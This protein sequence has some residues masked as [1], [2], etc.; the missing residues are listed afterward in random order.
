MPYGKQTCCVIRRPVMPPLARRNF[1]IS[2]SISSNVS[3]VSSRDSGSLGANEPALSA[4]PPNSDWTRLNNSF[5]RG[6]D[7]DFVF[8]GLDSDFDFAGEVAK[9]FVVFAGGSM[10]G[11]FDGEA[12]CGVSVRVAAGFAE[13]G[14]DISWP[15]TSSIIA[16]V[17][18]R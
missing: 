9:A 11:V 14:C 16:K 3:P 10:D 12:A 13:D 7:S 15:A 4:L 8:D 17:A 1:R 6:S 5:S 18:S 2:R